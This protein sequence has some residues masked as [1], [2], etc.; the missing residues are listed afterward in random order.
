[1]IDRNAIRAAIADTGAK[2]AIEK[3]ADGVLTNQVVYN[4]NTATTAATLTA[5]NVSGGHNEVVL[6]MTGTLGGAAALTLPTVADLVA[7]IPNAI[8]GQTYRLRIMN[9]SAGAFAW[10]VTTAT[11]WTLTGTMTIAQNTYREF[12]VTLTSK[13][14]AVLQSLGTVA[15]TAV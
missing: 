7:A 8:P 6:N 12:L 15:V 13:T 3:L 14:A 5:A 11:G 1:M 4:T 9:T 2:A 10:T